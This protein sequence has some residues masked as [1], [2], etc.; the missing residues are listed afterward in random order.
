[1]T[2]NLNNTASIDDD[3]FN[4]N[5]KANKIYDNNTI[6]NQ[7]NLEQTNIKNSTS[8]TLNVQLNHSSFE[9]RLNQSDLTYDLNIFCT[10]HP[11]EQLT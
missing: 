8:S 1:M 5:L 4:S 9:N 3:K 6:Q 11:E 10:E 7:T 2:A